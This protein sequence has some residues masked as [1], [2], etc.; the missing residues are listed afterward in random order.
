MEARCFL[1]TETK[2]S[3]LTTQNVLYS[4]LSHFIHLPTQSFISF[5]PFTR[6]I[7]RMANSSQVEQIVPQ[8]EIDLLEHM[9]TMV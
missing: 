3:W 7:I 2:R 4:L 9:F 1:V 6:S 5:H 8:E